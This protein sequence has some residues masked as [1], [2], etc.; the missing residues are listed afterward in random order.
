MF[1]LAPAASDRP[2]EGVRAIRRIEGALNQGLAGLNQRLV[3]LSVASAFWKPGL[4]FA[5]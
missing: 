4:P 1:R 3:C 2:A 5:G